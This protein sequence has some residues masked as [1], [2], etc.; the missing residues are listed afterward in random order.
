M[1]VSVEASR[2]LIIV[3][4]RLFPGHRLVFDDH[5]P[6]RPMEL[7]DRVGYHSE[8]GTEID[9]VSGMT[10]HRLFSSETD[11]QDDIRS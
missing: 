2:L 8:I 11:Q 1:T 6:L 10:S 4:H 7:Q 5:D 9:E 3:L